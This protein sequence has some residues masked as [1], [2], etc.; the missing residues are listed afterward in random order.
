MRFFFGFSVIE[1]MSSF[2]SI[3]VTNSG[4]A[5]LLKSDLGGKLLTSEIRGLIELPLDFT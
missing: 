4:P 1:F 5:E 2:L 3:G